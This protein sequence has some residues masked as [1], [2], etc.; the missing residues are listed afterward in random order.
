M[1]LTKALYRDILKKAKQFDKY[2]VLK[3]YNLHFIHFGMILIIIKKVRIS[4]PLLEKVFE[5]KAEER[6]IVAPI[7]N[8]F[9]TPH[10]FGGDT[11]YNTLRALF[12]VFISL[13]FIIIIIV[14]LPIF[15]IQLI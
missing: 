6:Q 3:V 9:Y 1:S 7:S 14:V 12:R 4:P 15:V 5:K 13:L 8:F 11:F 10:S 2:P